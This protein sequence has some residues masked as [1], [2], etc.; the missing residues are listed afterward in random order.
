MKKLIEIIFPPL[1][2]TEGFI[3]IKKENDCVGWDI[4]FNDCVEVE[5][6]VDDKKIGIGYLH[7]DKLTG[8][9]ELK[10]K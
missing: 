3:N 10:I 1:I 8:T 5:L 7:I 4:E 9:G 2:Q 6:F